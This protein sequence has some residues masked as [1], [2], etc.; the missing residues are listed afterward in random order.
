MIQ[1]LQPY[2][3]GSQLD[4]GQR[5]KRLDEMVEDFQ[6]YVGEAVE[7]YARLTAPEPG[8]DEVPVRP[9][10]V[11]ESEPC[12]CPGRVSEWYMGR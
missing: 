1:E 3:V 4:G 9:T 5:E 6:E 7:L 11:G 8:R 12:W 10:P 2:C